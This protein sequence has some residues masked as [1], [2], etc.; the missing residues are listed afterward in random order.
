MFSFRSWLRRLA[1]DLTASGG[2][3]R[4]KRRAHRQKLHRSPTVLY[5]EML[6][7]Y[8]MPSTNTWTGGAVGSWNVAGNWSLGHVPGSGDDVAIANAAVTDTSNAATIDTLTL[9]SGATLQFVGSSITTQAATGPSVTL[10]GAFTF[11]ASSSITASAGLTIQ[12]GGS[13]AGSGNIT[14]SVSNSG[15]VY[16][17]GALT[18]GTLTITGNYTQN[19]T[20]TL[21][22]D[23]GGNTVGTQYDKLAVSGA[24]TLA[25][26]LGAD[27]IN[28]FLPTLAT[29]FQPLTATA[30]SGTFGALNLN[31][32]NGETFL[33][34]QTTTSLNL[35]AVPTGTTVYWTG[36]TGNWTT[37]SDWS[38]NTVPGSSAVVYIPASGTVTFSSGTSSIAGLNT[39]GRVHALRRHAHRQRKSSGR[40]HVYAF[41]GSAE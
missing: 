28:G 4:R 14:G 38:T 11:D 20:G 29:S 31:L 2:R 25:G 8:I 21:S 6:E 39:A 32:G 33:P 36:G 17:G 35:E 15:T 40:Q 22:L 41:R 13:L 24:V 10:G 34:T 26:T 18:A 37:A 9:N 3:L 19:P 27:L 23:V 7:P 30:I 5:L 1:F 16:P 12:S